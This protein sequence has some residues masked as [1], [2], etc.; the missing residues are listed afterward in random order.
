[1]ER[2]SNA[3]VKE[4]LK[5][6]VENLKPGSGKIWKNQITI[7]TVPRITGLDPSLGDLSQP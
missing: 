5:D 6:V 3:R 1:V 7:P 2:L 4:Q